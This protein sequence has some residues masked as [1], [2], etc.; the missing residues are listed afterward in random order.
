MIRGWKNYI[1][2]ETMPASEEDIRRAEEELRIKLPEDYKNI[3]KQNQGKSPDPNALKVGRKRTTV[4]NML[5]HFSDDPEFRAD[6]ILYNNNLLKDFLPEKVVV[7]ADTPGG[8][9]FAFDYRKDASSP[10]VVFVSHE[11]PPENAT[12]PVAHSFSEL[13]GLLSDE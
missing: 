12:I 10:L 7:F 4:F 11:E 6:N 8:D 5:M 3:V 9:F 2:D 1:W 13:L